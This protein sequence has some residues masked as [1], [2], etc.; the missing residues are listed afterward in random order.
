VEG[1][2]KW[3][4][5]IPQPELTMM[6]EYNKQ[7]MI[8][9]RSVP[10]QYETKFITKKGKILSI[11]ITVS[12]IPDTNDFI[13]SV[14][15]ISDRKQTET[16]LIQQKEELSD[17]AHLM[18][19]DIRNSLSAIEG[20]V[21]LIEVKYDSTYVDRINSQ[22]VYMRE[23][24]D[25]S[26]EL[27]EAGRIIDKSEEVN[28]NELFDEIAH[29]TIPPEINYTKDLLPSVKADRKKTSQIVKN[30]I[31]NAVKHGKPKNIKIKYLE[32]EN[33]HVIYV[34]NDGEKIDIEIVREAFEAVFST[35]EMLELHG[36]TIVKK[37]IEAHE[38]DISL[39]EIKEITSF[40]IKIPK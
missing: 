14:I 34:Q 12:Q 17:F 10:M 28:L 27:A 36:L 32:K 8:D 23:L 30:L 38:W 2:M 40:I 37:L 39:E 11:L 3:T 31:E 16:E 33:E 15:D 7:R 6:L 19:H 1:K 5:F 20:F 29:I 13:T 24:L 4:E 18:A 26:I 35:R 25:R 22:L 9:P 21:D